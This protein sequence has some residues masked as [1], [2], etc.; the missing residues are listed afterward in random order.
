[1]KNKT[2]VVRGQNGSLTKIKADCSNDGIFAFHP[3]LLADSFLFTITHRPSEAA[4]GTGYYS[5]DDA[6]EVA[7]QFRAAL[8]ADLAKDTFTAEMTAKAL[9]I[10]K[11]YQGV[12]DVEEKKPMSIKEKLEAAKRAVAAR[13]NPIPPPA[14]P[15]AQ[16]PEPIA[17]IMAKLQAI[18][19]KREINPPR[20][21][22]DE[23]GKVQLFNG[24]DG[25]FMVINQSVPPIEHL[26]PLGSTFTATIPLTKQQFE[27]LEQGKD[28]DLFAGDKKQKALTPC[29]TCGKEF[30]VLAKHRC[31]T[32]V[33]QRA[34]D[35]FAL[36]QAA[37]LLSEF[38]Q[39]G[40]IETPLPWVP[41]ETLENIRPLP[42]AP[43]MGCKGF[44]GS[45]DFTPG[46][47]CVILPPPENVVD[48]QGTGRFVG[49]ARDDIAKMYA[50]MDAQDIADSVSELE[51]DEDDCAPQEGYA[52]FIDCLFE[53][54]AA[55]DKTHLFSTFILPLCEAV[56]MENQAENWNTVEYGKGP[57]LLSRKL[58]TA[59]DQERPPGVVFA[60]SMTAEYRACAEVL[61]RYATVVVQG[62]R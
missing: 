21:D 26:M 3:S 1:M 45:L 40:V 2:I 44:T 52:L 49:K 4:L 9:K 30:K 53:K 61:K 20:P 60:S 14:A 58:Q 34:E 10:Y 46:P 28:V 55:K 32:A 8:G 16:E 5:M 35:I 48:L 43:P 57:G 31:E 12:K 47:G 38:V 51:D 42:T 19:N 59:L 62:V 29:P 25:G 37:D 7:D 23:S 6:V 54:G 50:N 11:D 27:D 24:A 17:P 36:Q 56:A 18:G 13:E 41:V 15:V 39:T 33:A 22:E